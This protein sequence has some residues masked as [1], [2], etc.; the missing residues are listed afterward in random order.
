[1]RVRARACWVS[2]IA[3]GAATIAWFVTLAWGFKVP[4]RIGQDPYGYFDLARSLSV[5][6]GFT[7]SHPWEDW[8]PSF[9]PG[10]PAVLAALFSIVGPRVDIARALTLIIAAACPLLLVLVLRRAEQ[11]A[12]DA[13]PAA[14]TAVTAGAFLAACPLLAR[15]SFT[16][17]SDGLAIALLLVTAAGALGFSRAP[18]VL[19]GAVLGL[20]AACAVGVRY[21]A[22]PAALL[23]VAL[24]AA[25]A[26]RHSRPRIA[27]PLFAL[28]AA[29]AGVTVLLVAFVGWHTLAHH[30][31]GSRWS[32]LVAF[33]SYAD[34]ADGR[35]AW[36]MPLTLAYGLD[37][38][39]PGIV[40][41]GL[42]LAAGAGC[43]FGPSPVVRVLLAWIGV[44][45]LL[46]V[47]L[48]EHNTRFWA[49][50][51]P[52]IAAL[53]AHGVARL[54][55]RAHRIAACLVVIAVSLAGGAREA[56][57]MGGQAAAEEAR[58]GLVEHALGQSESLR[59]F[60]LELSPPLAARFPTAETLDAYAT[61][62][63][64]WDS[65]LLREGPCLLLVLDGAAAQWQS[66]AAWTRIERARK[67]DRGDHESAGG[68]VA[69]RF[70]C[71]PS[72]GILHY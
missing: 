3:L 26:V 46:V 20:S 42:A 64:E 36:G 5:G 58:L 17:M 44:S 43:L 41:T 1:V 18:S 15:A 28:V 37:L 48:P 60:T 40:G 38:L 7:F 29:A 39:R 34:T 52:A 2:P 54:G 47:G 16:L 70:A 72:G 14:E 33:A 51:A 55:K 35:L 32:P 68:A 8:I 12:R 13:P 27:A 71:G 10:Y 4:A 24:G 23:F 22:A 25:F 56:R 62:D 9:A 57:R 69:S 50:A 61:S 67:R 65:A 31:V 66:T 49:L 21:A 53:G 19:R 63:L 6:R 59:I 11:P 30:P 45:M